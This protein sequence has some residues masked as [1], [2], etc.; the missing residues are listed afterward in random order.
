MGRSESANFLQNT[1]LNTILYQKL[2]WLGHQA[3]VIASNVSK[4]DLHGETR[5]EIPTFKEFL[6]SSSI[7]SQISKGYAPLP[8]RDTK[9]E[10]KREMEVLEINKNVLNHEATVALIK[11]F[12]GFHK[13]VLSTSF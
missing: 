1:N 11:S 5:K 7:P 3:N 9:E 6:K 10:I 8:V 2:H 12:H 13:T 4:A